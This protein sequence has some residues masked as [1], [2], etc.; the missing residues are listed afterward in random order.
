MKKVERKLSKAQITTICLLVVSII[1]GAA[2]FTV[3]AI[4]KN[5][6]SGSTPSTRPSL[7]LLE[8]ESS[9]L[10]QPVA[11]PSIEESDILAIE[12]NNP[13]GRFGVSRYPDDL[14][15]FMFHYYVNGIE[16]FCHPRKKPH[17]HFQPLS[18]PSA[19]PWS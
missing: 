11:Y 19:L 3:S 16:Y 8:G 18:F 4:L 1:L 6:S 12:V 17:V 5:K 2:Y 10:N 9:Y 13:T 7:D 14:G 15:S